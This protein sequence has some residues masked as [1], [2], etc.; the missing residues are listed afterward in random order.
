VAERTTLV[1]YGGSPRGDESLRA[2]AGAARRSGETLAVVTLARQ[3]PERKRCCDTRSVYWNGVLRELAASDLTKAR[4]V[5]EDNPDVELDV[6]PVAVGRA[7]EAIA[8]R[9]AELGVERVVLADPR[10]CGLGR[11]ELRRLRR[12]CRAVL[13]EP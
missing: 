3:E 7:A 1:V 9:A 11:R 13:T 2:A 10:A 6:L 4:L 8:G 12:D 5:V